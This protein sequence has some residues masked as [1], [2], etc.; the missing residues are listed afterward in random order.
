MQR[1]ENPFEDEL[2]AQEWISSVEGEKGKVRDR[3]IYPMLEAWSS[4]ISGTIVEIGSGQ[5]ICSQYLGSFFGQ[6]IG[7]EPS[8]V[9]T[10]RAIELYG[11]NQNR[12]F[13]EGNA[14][15]LPIEDGTIDG[16]FSVNVWFHLAN[17]DNAAIELARILKKGG[18]FN[19]ITA[20]P[21]SY[22]AWRNFFEH[23]TEEG[24]LISGKVNVPVNPLSR[25]DVYL[26]TMAEIKDS[27]ENAGL[28]I[29]ETKSLGLIS[30]Y[31]NSPLFV[32]VQGI[33]SA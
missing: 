22:E 11:K 20:N 18:V 15:S 12:T 21:G 25:N 14:Y 26:H 7:I 31:P 23:Y 5:G 17:L 32:S 33:K 30:K 9:L 10:N 28:T 27:L 13:K 24:K 29:T 2:V 6:Y 19:I 4:E 16:V 3:E 1:E 8:Q